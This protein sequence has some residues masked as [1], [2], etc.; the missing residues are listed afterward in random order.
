M[1]IAVR[2]QCHAAGGITD[3]ADEMKRLDA[4]SAVEAAWVSDDDMV[5]WC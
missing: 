5:C 2:G 4:L 1:H 3:A